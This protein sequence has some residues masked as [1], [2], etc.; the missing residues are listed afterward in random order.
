[1]RNAQ[2]KTLT[3]PDNR[4]LTLGLGLATG[5]VLALTPFAAKA[6][7]TI[8]HGYSNFG[9]LK[10]GPDFTHL[11]YVNPDAPKGGEISIWAQGAF[12][13]FNQFTRKGRTAA[14]A[15]IGYERILVSTAD[16]PYGMYCFL[17]TT[18]EYPDDL[19]WVIFNLR[20]DVTFW[21]GTKMTAEDIAFTHNLFVE[22]GIAE[23]RAIIKDVVAGVEVSGPRQVKF[24][25]T[26]DSPKRDRIGFAGSGLA[27]SKKWFEE[28]GTKLDDRS[29]A[30]FM[31]TGAYKLGSFDYGRHVTY[32]RDPNYWGADHPMSVGQN[33][34]DQI[35]SVYF[36]DTTAA[37]EGFKAGAYTFRT[38][39]SSQNWAEDYDFPN[40][41]NG[42]VIKTEL[43]DGSVGT[44]QSFIFNLDKQV[45]QDPK[46]REAFGLMFN[47]EWSN[48]ALF[49]GLYS[50]VDS[51][52]PGIDLGASG[53]PGDEEIA[54]L[55]PL[56]EQGLLPESIL[57]DNAVLP[58]VHDAK[59]NKPSRKFYRQANKLLDE[60]GWEIGSS[61]FLEKDGQRMKATFLAYSP[62]FDR[63]IN[64]LVENL[65]R[66]GVDAKLERV[67]IPQY[68]ERTRSGDFDLVTHSIGMGF[69]PGTG[70]EQWFH[71][72][73]AKDSSRNLMRLR[74][75]AVD[76]LLPVVAQSE[77]L[78]ELRTST[79]ALDRVLRHI[80]FTI[81][82]WYKNKHT[83]AYYDIFAHPEELPPLALGEMSWWWYDADKAAKLKAAGVLK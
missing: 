32:E 76:A 2:T 78:D 7:T 37:M 34:F 55:K 31:A 25:F 83:V 17:C 60:A 81:P 1:M 36:A 8:S 61:G 48:E 67:D 20:D 75:P 16:D 11:D 24:T 80:G 27:L 15:T 33:N 73:T 57:S 66:L 18:M 63:V 74:D 62:S 41:R 50:R 3:R 14:N 10:Y 65:K 19:S 35:T 56:V 49:R 51:F 22:Q 70:L 28:T 44:A 69:E 21:D 40:I 30:P 59:E 46:V 39:S 13:S 54:I 5:A 68:V 47:F 43:P 53:A 42:Y 52:W 58:P 4:I 64:P 29:D 9:E 23:Y 38:E 45:W 77:T 82:Q 12:D 6:D 72:K 71:S 26:E 79:N